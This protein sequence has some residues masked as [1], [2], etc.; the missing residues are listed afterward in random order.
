[1]AKLQIGVETDTPIRT[2]LTPVD[3]EMPANI[4]TAV[5][6]LIAWLDAGDVHPGNDTGELPFVEKVRIPFLG[7]MTF[8]GDVFIHIK[9]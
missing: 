1:M 8:R 4:E 9:D 3:R 5:R 6:L 2:K 7:N